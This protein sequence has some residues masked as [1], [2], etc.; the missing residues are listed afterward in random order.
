MENVDF[1][2]IKEPVLRGNIEKVFSDAF[3]LETLLLDD[4][5]KEV[6]GCLRKTILVK[7]HTSRFTPLHRF[8]Y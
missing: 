4:A 6:A 5:S 7:R 1:S 8:N 3:R 2:F